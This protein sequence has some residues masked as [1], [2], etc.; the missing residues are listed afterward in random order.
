MCLRDF[1][2]NASLLTRFV[3][4]SKCCLSVGLSFSTK[5]IG[6]DY[7][8]V[9][10]Y[11][12]KFCDSP[13]LEHSDLKSEF[14]FNSSTSNFYSSSKLFTSLDVNSSFA[15]CNTVW[16]FWTLSLFTSETMD[17]SWNVYTKSNPRTVFIISSH[18]IPHQSILN[19]TTVWNFLSHFYNPLLLGNL[20]WFVLKFNSLSPVCLSR[21]TFSSTQNGL[22]ALVTVI[23]SL[24]FESKECCCSFTKRVSALRTGM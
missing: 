13:N 9:S 22:S 1:V 5:K 11:A 12:P 19:A 21:C 16:N 15:V 2:G 20:I 17:R 7:L 3:I 4:I 10:F 24:S 8:K 14:F 23:H 6:L 18:T